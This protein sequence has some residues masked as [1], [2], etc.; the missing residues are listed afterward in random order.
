ML[1]NSLRLMVRPLA[2]GPGGR[3]PFPVA[4][5]T[6]SVTVGKS[7]KARTMETVTLLESRGAY[8]CD[9]GG[10]SSFGLICCNRFVPLPYPTLHGN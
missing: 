7:H 5:L 4:V 1:A 8:M 6:S 10:L 2:S 3:I 9:M